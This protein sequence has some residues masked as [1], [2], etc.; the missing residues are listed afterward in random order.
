MD[1][2]KLFIKNNI[3]EL[4][5]RYK[6]VAILSLV[7]IIHKDFVPI[8]KMYEELKEIYDEILNI[9][10]QLCTK[11]EQKAVEEFDIE[12]LPEY[13][14]SIKIVKEYQEILALHYAY[15]KVKNQFDYLKIN[16]MSIEFNSKEEL[17]YLNIMAILIKNKKYAEAI[18]IGEDI[19]KVSNIATIWNFLGHVYYKLKQYGKALE[20]YNCYI[21]RN[22]SDVEILKNIKNIYKEVLK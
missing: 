22:D 16:K 18:K 13:L 10:Q 14:Q 5:N 15:T 8:K 4:T 1:K 6:A 7:P 19:A 11:D 21:K 3:E 12:N 2:K 9:V 17:A 20:A